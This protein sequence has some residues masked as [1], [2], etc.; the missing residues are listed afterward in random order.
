MAKEFEGKNIEQAIE[1]ACRHFGVSKEKLD[2]EIIS[3][4]S[5]GL[6][7]IGAKKARIKASLKPETILKQREE[8]AQKVLKEIISAAGFEIEIKTKQEN[9]KIYIELTGIDSSLLLAKRGAPLNALQY[10]VNKIVAKRLGV[11]AKIVFDIEG[12]REDREKKLKSLA[13]KAAREAKKT[14]KPFSLPPMPAHERRVIHL[15]IKEMP[16]VESK[17]RGRGSERHV[18]VF[19]KNNRRNKRRKQ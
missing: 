8:E 14:R 5:T 6:F 12:F 19:P 18:V 1:E 4:G 11:G 2:I 13:Q 17:S 9:G 15:T 10:L 7:G 16:G 3:Q